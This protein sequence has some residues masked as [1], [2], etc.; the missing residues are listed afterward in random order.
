MHNP[1]SADRVVLPPFSRWELGRLVHSWAETGRALPVA[2]VVS[3]I[4]DVCEALAAAPPGDDVVVSLDHV[5]IDQ[6]GVARIT[7]RPREAVPA[8]SSLLRE[9]L[10]AGRGDEAIPAAAWP[11]LGQGLAE[12][13]WVR[14]ASTDVIQQQ[15]RDALGPPAAREEVLGCCAV[16]R[17][18]VSPPPPMVTP[19]IPPPVVATS[20]A[21]PTAPELEADSLASSSALPLPLPLP[22]PELAPVTVPPWEVRSIV[23]VEVDL[24]SLS[25]RLRESASA[26]DPRVRDVHAE[27]TEVVVPL[28]VPSMVGPASELTAAMPE[29]VAE[30]EVEALPEVEAEALP[31]V[32]AVAAA[33]APVVAAASAPVAREA[34][35]PAVHLVIAPPP[36]AAPEPRRTLDPA[37]TPPVSAAPAPI[38]PPAR[39]S[40]APAASS[41]VPP[42]LPREAR[43]TTS[44]PPEVSL[45]P[46]IAAPLPEDLEEP[47]SLLP[48]PVVRHEPPRR[49]AVSL[50][51]APAARLGPGTPASLDE[52]SIELPSESPA[53][54]VLI[55]ILAVASAILVA[56]LLGLI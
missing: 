28:E 23:P 18:Q 36:P 39:A 45:S 38:E 5:I 31:E 27:A 29:V 10:A 3:I 7:V 20:M 15:L 49:R 17:G 44:R 37:S 12:D 46:R 32:E 35:A 16:M 24:A 51:A 26:S 13:P 34:P 4:D 40:D 50:P 56:W 47:P 52:S 43:G 42:A 48:R 8:V 14:P 2:V 55:G 53:Q 9:A 41:L 21:P 19:S 33:S 30:P 22:S 6:S 1:R 54:K 11:V 25:P